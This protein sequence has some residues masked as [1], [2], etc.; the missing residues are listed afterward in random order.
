MIVAGLLGDLVR[1]QPARGLEVEHEDLR[2]Q[3]RGGDPLPF[4]GNF[5]LVQRR[6]NA[7]RAEQPGAEIGD[8]NADAHRAL[9]RQAGDRHQPAHALRDLIDAGPLAIRAVL[10]EAGNA[11][12]DDALVDLA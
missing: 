12:E 10:T 5:A 7:E 9:A 4:A 6:Q 8:R 3:Q 1:L 2:L 11:G